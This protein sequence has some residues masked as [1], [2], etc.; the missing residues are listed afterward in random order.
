MKMNSKE[1]L[2]HLVDKDFNEVICTYPEQPAYKGYTEK[3]MIKIIEQDL[4]VLD[5]LKKYI[6]A[7]GWSN[8]YT[9]LSWEMKSKELIKIERWFN[10]R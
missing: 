3:D 4:E 10:D 6:R 1:A 9:L 7:G 8:E 2:K 5:I